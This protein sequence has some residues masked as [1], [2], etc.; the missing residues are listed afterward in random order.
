MGNGLVC[1]ITGSDK[2]SEYMTSSIISRDK[3]NRLTITSPRIRWMLQK[4]FLNVLG[5]MESLNQFSQ[6]HMW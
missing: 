1:E 6:K 2:N 4:Y 3:E 5:N